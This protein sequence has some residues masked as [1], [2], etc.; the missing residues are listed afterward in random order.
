[1]EG[2]IR[3]SSSVPTF[4]VSDIAETARWYVDQLGFQLTGHVP[5]QEPYV[6]ASL[7][8]GRAELMLL[9]SPGYR[10]PDLASLRPAAMWD[11]YFRMSGVHAF[12]ARLEQE[13]F[14]KMRLKKQP[15]GDWEFEVRDPNGYILVFGGD[16]HIEPRGAAVTSGPTSPE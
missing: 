8:L 3:V 1:M 4:L 5:K 13:P 14:I 12:Y 11:A 9:N 15:Y 10:K 2:G 6:F 7:Q 16:A